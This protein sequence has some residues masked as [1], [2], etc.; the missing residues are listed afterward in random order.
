MKFR[1]FI[2]FL[3]IFISQLITAQTTRVINFDQL[4]ES[5]N[6]GEQVRVVIHYALCK[7][8][9]D[10]IEQTPTPN[11]ITGMDIDTYEYFAPGVVHNKVA[12]VV[13]STAKLIKNP[14]GKGMVY[15]YG[16]LRI[17][18]DNTVQVTAEYINP[19]TYKVLM[20]EVFIGKIN[21]G[22]NIFK[23]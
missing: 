2:S 21:E 22:I 10:K 12:F 5:L 8:A 9:A 1:V 13:F 16:K 18:A 14:K 20:S 3:L 7:W 4:M 23:H 11:A 6:A 19:K 15:N 17:N